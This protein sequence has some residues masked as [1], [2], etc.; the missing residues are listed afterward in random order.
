MLLEGLE[1]YVSDEDG[2]G[3]GALIR[4]LEE[5]LFR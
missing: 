2:P 1:R 3:A 5:D 4:A